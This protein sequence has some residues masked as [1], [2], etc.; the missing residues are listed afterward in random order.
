MSAPKFR[1]VVLASGT[2]TN[3]RALF[4]H[5]ARSNRLEAV[6]L[7]CD[8]PGIGAL[9]AAEDFGV[10]SHVIAHKDEAALLRLLGELAPAWACLAGYKRIVGQGFLDFFHDEELGYSKVMNVHPSLLP[11]YPGLH[12]YERAFKDGVKISGV[13]VHL[14]DGGLDTGLPILQA[15][16]LRDD[17]DT[18]ETFMAKG[19]QL[20]HA[21]FVRA[22][23][24]AAEKRIRVVEREGS[25][26]VSLE[27]TR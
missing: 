26:F 25:R 5:A 6:A 1:F 10:P 24:L 15:P 20:E 27:E 17:G 13:T 11:A 16:F 19:R 22:L 18:L 14:V 23:D 12:G 21:M 7:I 4:E 2:G 9:Q 8:R 3:A